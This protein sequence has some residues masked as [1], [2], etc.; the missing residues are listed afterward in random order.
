M[1]LR[2]ALS[3][4]AYLPSKQATPQ[5]L[6]CHESIQ[7][8]FSSPALPQLCNTLV[9]RALLLTADELEE[10]EADTGERA[11]RGAHLAAV[12]RIVHGDLPLHT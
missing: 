2:N 7:S 9:C 4:S 8:F 1:F 6:R 12:A 5:A 3:T 10:Y 11:V